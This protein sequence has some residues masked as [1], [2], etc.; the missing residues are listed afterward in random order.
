MRLSIAIMRFK[1]AGIIVI[2]TLGILMV[3][4]LAADAQ[5]SGKVY[6]LGFISSSVTSES[7]AFLKGLRQGLNER[8]YEE[9]KNIEIEYRFGK[10]KELP[11]L[12]EDLVKRGVDLIVGGGSQ[13]IK[14]A[15][16][17]T[18]TIPIVMTNSG[19]AQRSGFVA[20]LARPG[21]NI[22]G[23]T[24][25]S[26]ELAAKRLLLLQE[27]VP[28]LSKVAV[29]W[30]PLHP[31][32]PNTFKETQDAS[33]KLGLQL[34]SLEVKTPQ[35]FDAA[36]EMALKQRAEGL[37]VLRDPFMV[38]HRALIA[39]FAMAHRLPAIYE[40]RDFI[41]AGGLML[42]GPSFFDLYRRSATHI[43]KILQGANPGELPVERPLKFTFVINLKTA[44]AIGLTPPP[45][46]LYQADEVIR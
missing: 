27:T 33:D 46:L 39:K 45:S 28:G 29:L 31:N 38:R 11:K 37:V 7:H 22:T 10:K 9:G 6:R 36:F 44:E 35:D 13:G 25:I 3:T 5:Q 14:A 1:I 12:A 41:E 2:L 20:S 21:G 15:K 24:Q 16:K 42:Y 19:N 32:T 4:S 26:P 23:M 43:D 30:Y 8:G 34:I 17:A 18:Q 40:T